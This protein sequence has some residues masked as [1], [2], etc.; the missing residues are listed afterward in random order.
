MVQKPKDASVGTFRIRTKGLDRWYLKHEFYIDGVRKEVTVPKPVTFELGFNPAWSI[1]QAKARCSQLNRERK[2][3]RGQHVRTGRKAAFQVLVDATYFPSEDVQGFLAHLDEVT[4]GS[5]NHLKKLHSHFATV[6]KMVCALKITPDKYSVSANRIYKWLQER[7]FSVDY[8]KKIIANLNLWARYVSRLRGTYFEV[9]RA[10]KGRVRSAIE[11][12]QI[13]QRGVR[14]AAKPLS[15]ELLAK[16]KN[17]LSVEHYNWLH[18]S[19][20]FGL[21]PTEVDLLHD[22]DTWRLETQGELNVLAVYQTKLMDVSIER[23]WKY[24]PI[25][26]TEQKKSL[27]IINSGLFKRPHSKT[28]QKHLGAGI[29]L[30]SGRKGFQDIALSR[31]QLFQDIADYLGHSSVETTFKHY[32]DR[33]RVRVSKVI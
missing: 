12:A 29:T 15:I 22:K 33:T 6:Q 14:R 2:I 27:E 25:L 32:R 7:R 8:S 19:L 13:G 30:Y 3:E 1:I 11:G 18:L 17:I 16:A 21:R 10:P 28:T 5:S 4:H 26:F 9:V 23:R 31:G 20:W 24:I